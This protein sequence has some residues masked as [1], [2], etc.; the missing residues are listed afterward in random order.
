M[1]IK[2]YDEFVSEKLNI[3]PVSKDS[4]NSVPSFVKEEEE[5]LKKSEADHN[6]AEYADFI[7]EAYAKAQNDIEKNNYS[8]E[9]RTDTSVTVGDEV[10]LTVR[11]YGTIGYHKKLE[12]TA[13]FYVAYMKLYTPSVAD[14]AICFGDNHK[15]FM[16]DSMSGAAE[17]AFNEKKLKQLNGLICDDSGLFNDRIKGELDK[18]YNQNSTWKTNYKDDIVDGIKKEVKDAN[19]SLRVMRKGKEIM[20]V[21]LL[22]GI[23]DK[24][25]GNH[26]SDAFGFDLRGGK[27]DGNE[28]PLMY[29]SPFDRSG[30]NTYRPN[31]KYMAMRNAEDLLKECGGKPWRK[32]IYKNPQDIIV[33]T[34]RFVKDCL[35]LMNLYCG[36][37]VLH[38]TELKGVLDISIADAYRQSQQKRT[39]E[40]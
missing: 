10:P 18:I 17:R 34:L 35:P 16:G 29:L 5:W 32:V 14:P 24:K 40:M 1:K 15:L 13:E 33:K 4:L 36:G 11:I 22:I 19:V 27:I 39:H 8:I 26:F 7:T 12:Y 31:L 25:S 28:S 38:G 6:T 23:C 30:N 2:G 3:Q 21:T 37:D 9:I 20:P